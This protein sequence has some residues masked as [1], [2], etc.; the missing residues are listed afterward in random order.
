MSDLSLYFDFI[1]PYSHLAIAQLEAGGLAGADVHYTPVVYGAILTATG[2][3]GPVENAA[4][5]R[6]TFLDVERR[7]QQLGL[8]LE[9]A[10][11]HPFRSIDALRVVCAFS[12]QP[13]VVR[14]VGR[15]SHACWGD[16]AD[17]SDGSVLADVV[18]EVGLNHSDLAQRI[19]D[20]SIKQQLFDN[21]QR[22]LDRGVFGVPTFDLDG[23]LFWGHDRMTDL[24][25]RLAGQ[26]PP[27]KERIER[28][29][30]R[31][32]AVDRRK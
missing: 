18:A 11:A 13:Q 28:M 2:L 16:G 17:L 3:V 29:L 27:A 5:R 22:A 7:A 24:E 4:K 26:P 15:L 12:D 10:P 25:D 23:E 9:G 31:P 14:L 30:S 20:P 1:S 8:A 19:A 6:Y 21:T 32:R